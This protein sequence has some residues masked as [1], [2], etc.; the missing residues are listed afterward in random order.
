MVVT[1]VDDLIARIRAAI[2]EDERI[3]ERCGPNWTARLRRQAAAHRKLLDAHHP[4]KH[5]YG[6]WA[7]DGCGV[8][9]DL[10][11]PRYDIDECPVL[12]ALAEAYGIEA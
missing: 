10:D 6:D 7:C 11:E 8:T 3:A 12:L 5:D 4:V 9:G 2:G 1:T